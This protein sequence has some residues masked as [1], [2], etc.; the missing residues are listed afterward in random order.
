MITALAPA[1]QRATTSFTLSWGLLNIPV[2]AFTG[3]EE[4]RVKRME[5]VENTDV[6]VG[7]TPIRKDTEAVI[8]SAVVVR[9]AQATNGTW[10]VLTDAE[11]ADCTAVEP[12]VGDIV[13]FVPLKNVGDYLAETQYQVRPRAEK[14]KGNPSAIKA[15]SLLCQA[16]TKRKVCALV[17]VSLRGPARFGLLTADGTFT[18]VRT[19]D[20]IREARPMIEA[21]ISKDE[22][23]LAL[24][25]IDTVGTDVPVLLDETAPAVQAFV[26]SKAGGAAAPAAKPAPVMNDDIMSAL[27]ASIAAKKVAA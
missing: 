18:L 27:S 26:D 7:R 22:M 24:T 15:F 13:T 21:T 4:T 3:V 23:D 25:L 11:I 8:D 5:Y 10:V 17:K 6:L 9:K 20:S 16:M 12:G 2:S 14:G 1:P 19:A